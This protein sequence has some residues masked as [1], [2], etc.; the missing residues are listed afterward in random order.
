MPASLLS[1]LQG[2]IYEPVL[3]KWNTDRL[4][5]GGNEEVESEG[6]VKTS[7][8]CTLQEATLSPINVSIE[9]DSCKGSLRAD[10]NRK[11]CR[12]VRQT[13]CLPCSDKSGMC[14]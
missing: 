4:T 13:S 12:C 3:K 2:L 9:T 8:K 6:S 14:H 10:R 5:S 1:F 11:F 7:V